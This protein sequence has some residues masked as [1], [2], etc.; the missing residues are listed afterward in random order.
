MRDNRKKFPGVLY[1]SLNGKW[2][3]NWAEEMVADTITGVFSTF[4]ANRLNRTLFS[5]HEGDVCVRRT[6]FTR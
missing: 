4:I 6:E 3:F 2:G 1:V 5:A